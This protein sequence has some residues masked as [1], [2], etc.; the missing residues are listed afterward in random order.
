[1]RYGLVALTALV[2]V[3]F[4]FIQRYFDFS[5]LQHPWQIHRTTRIS[6]LIICLILNTVWMM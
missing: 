1:V 5:L 3:S 6:T 4:F 2:A